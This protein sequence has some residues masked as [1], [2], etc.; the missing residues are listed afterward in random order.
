M[1]ISIWKIRSNY[2]TVESEGQPVCDAQ[3]DDGSAQRREEFD[4]HL[5]AADWHDNALH[6]EE[7]R[8]KVSPKSAEAAANAIALQPTNNARFLRDPREDYQVF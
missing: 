8:V 3:T 2:I 4:H 6:E 1:Q 7:D 5:S